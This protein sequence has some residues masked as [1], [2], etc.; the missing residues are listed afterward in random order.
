[1]KHTILNIAVF[2]GGRSSEYSISLQSAHGVM[3]NLDRTKYRVLPIGIS[4][5]GKWFYYTGDIDRIPEDA[6]LDPSHCTPVCLVPGD[7]G[8]IYLVHS[9]GSQTPLDIDLALP[10]LHGKNGEDGTIQGLLQMLDIPLVGCGVLSSALC[11]DKDRAHRLASY[12]GILV[13][14]A[15]TVMAGEDRGSLYALAEEVGYPLYVKPVKQGS[16]Y[17]ITRVETPDKL[18]AAIDYAFQYDDEVIVEENIVGFEVGCA[19]MGKGAKLLVGEV[20]EIEIPGGF[21]DF[22][23]KYNLITS[24]IYVPARIDEALTA[25]VKETAKTLYRVLG[26]EGFARVD[27]FVTPGGQVYF[28]EINTIPGF[29]AH[30]RYPGMMGAAGLSF[31]AML[32]KLIADTQAQQQA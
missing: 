5:T 7:R 4:Q 17:G 32:D 28:N 26:C 19:V 2:F 23:E 30:S 20:D 24:S 14:R 6:W 15:A 10:I 16:S 31:S 25:R 12:A 1:M 3:S 18:E 11:M 27:M 13:P 22:T 9:D 29:T 21:F 8:G